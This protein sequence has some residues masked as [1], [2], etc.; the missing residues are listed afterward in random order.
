MTAASLDRETPRMRLISF[1]PIGKNG[2]AGFASVELAIGLRL[3]ELPV[4]AGGQNGPWVALP[5][6]PALDRE[7]RQRIGADGKPAFEPVAEWRDRETSNRFS[8]SVID[9]IR[10]IHP[11]VFEDMAA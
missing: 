9:L 5:R 4:F 2:L 10:A 8:A 1:K 11:D 3:H 6:R 7:R